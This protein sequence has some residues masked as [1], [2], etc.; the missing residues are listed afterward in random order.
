MRVLL[1]AARDPG[2]SLFY[3]AQELRRRG[4][5]DVRASVLDASAS[6]GVAFDIADI[7]DN[8]AEL[9][10]LI[11][12]ADVLHFV[13]LVPDRVELLGTKLADI[14]QR[15]SR[16]RIIVQLDGGLGTADTR[17]VRECASERAWSLLATR[18]G[19]AGEWGAHF[20]PPFIPWWRAPWTPLAEGTRSRESLRRPGIVFVSS[21]RPLQQN[22]ELELLVD[23]AEA[24]TSDKLR[25]EVMTNLAH[26]HVLR[27]RRSSHLTLAASRGGLGRS[28]LESLC[29]GVPVITKLD[30]D[31]AGSYAALAGGM[32]PPVLEP[33]ALDDAIEAIEPRGASDPELR[34]WATRVLDPQRWFDTC[35]ALWSGESRAA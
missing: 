35:A 11:A 21:L 2:G 23:K 12:R 27:R 10:Q 1:V 18:A 8:G 20:L 13:D 34:R 25:L 4:L 14:V 28:A 32:I 29:Q 19:L 26:R 30:D 9:S 24:H 5:A 3:L 17:R 7:H 33:E 31:L 22:P 6:P 15:G 16:V